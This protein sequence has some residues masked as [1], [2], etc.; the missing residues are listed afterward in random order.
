MLS[1]SFASS[2]IGSRLSAGKRLSR[3]WFTSSVAST[4]RTLSSS[5]GREQHRSQFL[6]PPS[7][8]DRLLLGCVSY[9]PSVT[10]IWDG[11]KQYLRSS[12]GGN[13]PNFDYALFTNYETQVA[14]LLDGSIDVAWNGPVAHVMAEDMAGGGGDDRQ[15]P[16]FVRS[17][18]M[19]DVD[20]NF[21][22]VALIRRDCLPPH[23]DINISSSISTLF[24]GKTIATGSMDSPQGHIVP[25]DWIENKHNLKGDD[26]TI[27]SHD[28]DLGKHGDTA[29]GEIMAM[30]ALINGTDNTD[31]TLISEMMYLRGLDGALFDSYGIDPKELKENVVLLDDA[32]PV[33]D[34]C[35]FDA[36]IGDPIA[37]ATN[38]SKSLELAHHNIKIDAFSNAVLSMDM[39]DPKQEPIMRM[40]GIQRSWSKPR[41]DPG[42]AVRAAL[43]R[44]GLA[45]KEPPGIEQRRMMS[46]SSSSEQT[47]KSK[48]VAVIGAGISG[49]QVIRALRSKGYDVTA[50]DGDKDGVGGLWR[51]NYLSYGSQAPK[52]LFEFPDFPFDDVPFGDFPTGEQIKNYIERYADHF[53]LRRDVVLNTTV[54]S[55]VQNDENNS[56]NIET[57]STTPDGEKKT[58]THQFDKL[59]VSTGLYASDR[60][61]FPALVQEEVDKSN[62]GDFDGDILHSHELQRPEQVKGK[63]VV[64]VGG[65]KSA[66]DVAVA[67][68]NAGAEKVT[69]LSRAAH[70]PTPRKIADIIPFQYVFLS[71]LGQNLVLGLTGPL[72]GCS[73]S[74]SSIWHHTVGK[75]IMPPIFKIVEL[76]FAAQ[77]RNVSGPTSPFLKK[78][79]VVEDFY[80]YA[81]VLDYS[82]RDK[83]E[84]GD[85]DWK[86]G[87]IEK[88][89][90]DGTGIELNGGG[91]DHL[92][93]DV[94][95]C[96]T[97]FAKDYSIFDSKTRERLNVESD[98]LYLFNHTVPP[99]VDNLAFVGSELA[100]ISNISGYGLQ[101]AWL[102]NF[103]SN[104]SSDY[105]KAAMEQEV[106]EL[107]QWKRKWMPNTPSRASL[108]LLHQ[109]H[110]YDRLLRDLGVNQKRKSNFLSEWF[111]PYHSED[112]NG[113]LASLDQSGN[114]N[115]E[116]RK[117]VPLDII[118]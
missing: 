82:F 113:V 73:P 23:D 61:S 11:M 78:A 91:G 116:T 21:R 29:V 63:R 31:C 30:K 44:R 72:P 43:Y 41:V 13:L 85:I 56:W 92:E 65:G 90:D 81:H 8:K 71:R 103:W 80:G 117:N 68:S 64:V 74:H 62:N 95:I 39:S 98:G 38:T 33:F 35:S 57:V 114:S 20:C 104:G 83:V 26:V 50:F 89:V 76:L 107:K 87:S 108:V 45:K 75:Y 112:F 18:G 99:N 67:S 47:S 109:I 53:D 36:L 6:V 28:Y 49:L 46:S 15:Y 3:S 54:T 14:A 51:S 32:P 77:F 16:S 24:A 66:I 55:A 97:G 42:G 86:I 115:Y 118:K 111:M 110:F 52:Q 37:R 58:Q 7:R 17:V 34:H 19:R 106:E 70:W 1:R 94:V 93:A 40:E 59:I 4:S 9:D 48:S 96:G 69:M 79:G 27:L 102:A 25:V 2:P 5:A 60:P 12:S 105:D 100:V 22:S 101:A 88:F 10:T 84:A